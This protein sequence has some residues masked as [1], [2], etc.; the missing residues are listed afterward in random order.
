MSQEIQIALVAASA[1][2]FGAL[3]SQI[4]TFVISVLDK[5]H[6]RKV[7]LRE[8]YEEMALL[9]SG[10]LDWVLKAGGAKSIKELHA[11]ALPVNA[12]QMQI[13]CSIYFSELVEPSS[14]YVNACNSYYQSI[15]NLFNEAVNIP[16]AYQSEGNEGHKQVQNEFT[17]ARQAFDKALRQYS[18]VYI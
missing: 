8:K 2:V 11:L 9:Y 16:A 17:A 15:A 3:A 7:L 18:N 10:S 1:A 13:F 6:Q 12:R 14:N 5:K 4:T